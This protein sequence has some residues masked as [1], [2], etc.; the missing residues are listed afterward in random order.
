M[1]HTICHDEQAKR[2]VVEEL[3]HEAYLEYFE[4]P[5]GS[6]DFAH[7]YTPN[8]IRGRGIATAIIRGALDYARENGKMVVPGCPFVRTYVDRHEKY[9]ELIVD[10]WRHGERKR[11]QEQDR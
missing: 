8:E 11:G 10:S 3:G 2:F 4:L 5:D 6:L 7:T 9:R 1:E